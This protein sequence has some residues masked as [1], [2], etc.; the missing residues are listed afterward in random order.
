[1]SEKASVELDLKINAANSANTVKELKQGLKGL[2]DELNNVPAGSEAFKRLTSAINETES[3]LGDLNDSFNTL[4]GSGLERSSKSLGLLREGFSNLDFEKV[5]IGL[6]GLRT[7]LAS[8][9]IMLLVQ[10]VTYLISNFEDLKNSTGILG[11]IM[12]GLGVVI[13][14]IKE[15]FYSLTDAI[16]LTN[17]TLDK[18]GDKIKDIGDKSKQLLDIQTQGYDNQIAKLKAL[19]KETYKIEQE[20]LNNQK[21]FYTQELKLLNDLNAKKGQLTEDEKKRRLELSIEIGKINNQIEINEIEHNKRLIKNANKPGDKRYEAY[22]SFLEKQKALLSEEEAVY[23]Y[24]EQQKTEVT[25]QESDLQG[26]IFAQK[27]Q[28][29]KDAEKKAFDDFVMYRQLSI[30]WTKQSMSL[31]SDMTSI[32]YSYQLE[33]AKGNAERELE[34]KKRAY[35]AEQGFKVANIV[36]DTTLGMIKAISQNPP[37]SPIGTISASMVGLAGALAIVKVLATKFNEGG[38]GA[39]GNIS[40]PTM[41]SVPQPINQVGNTSTLIIQSDKRF[42]SPETVKQGIAKAYLVETEARETINRIS[43]IEDKSK[44]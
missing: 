16:G 39:T 32:F 21:H 24:F 22:K 40:P 44:I 10:G 35:K 11:S 34:I 9:G 42:A 31:M 15:A 38:G 12:R 41:S 7:A 28:Q 36:I 1:M 8:T 33:Q 29:Y 2:K 43:K 30:D 3:R 5:K 37:P 18:Y 23:A 17:S 26:I 19:G 13:D 4:T 25:Q 27:I 20:K 6:N 14:A